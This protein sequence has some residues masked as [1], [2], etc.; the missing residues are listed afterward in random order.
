[1]IEK[2]EIPMDIQCALQDPKW[3]EVCYVPESYKDL[4]QGDHCYQN[5][6]RN[7]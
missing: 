3:K 2:V 7:G 4:I 5:F 1:M 6:H